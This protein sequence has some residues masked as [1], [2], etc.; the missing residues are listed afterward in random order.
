MGEEGGDVREDG[1]GVVGGE[2]GGECR[3]WEGGG[4][5]GQGVGEGFEG[6]AGEGLVRVFWGW[7]VS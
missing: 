5:G 2:E 3:F 6:Y 1:E 4:V 7:W